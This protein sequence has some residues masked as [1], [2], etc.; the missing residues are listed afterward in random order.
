VRSAIDWAAEIAGTVIWLLDEA[1]DRVPVYED[2]GDGRRW[3]S[4]GQ[5]GCRL[6]LHHIWGPLLWPDVP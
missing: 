2:W 6:R 5:L 4:Y 3:H 1:L